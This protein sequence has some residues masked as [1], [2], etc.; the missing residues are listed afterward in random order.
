MYDAACLFE[1]DLQRA[2]GDLRV[3][4]HR[5]DDVSALHSLRQAGCLK[6]RFPHRGP[7]GWM[8][9][10]TVN[11]SGGIVGGD[12]LDSRFVLR[13]A[14][15][16]TIASQAAER[17][18]RALSG[19]PPACI[20]T[21]IYLGAAASA[22]WLPQETILFDRCALDRR[23]DVEMAADSWFLGLEMLVFGR[24]AMGEAVEHGSIRDLIR[25]RR[26]GRVILHDAVRLHGNVAALLQRPAIAAS[27]R[28]VATILHVAAQAEARLEAVRA[29]LA[30]IPLEA[31][32]S[33]WDGMLVIRLLSPDSAILRNAVIAVLRP[34]RGQRT[35][36]R[37]WGC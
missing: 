23:L 19:S 11:T 25:L 4:V 22:E 34:L 32:A 21:R 10:V 13:N 1:P 35:L 33:A 17:I 12:R 15:H 27:A 31:A 2:T 14:A 29:V 28:A 3:S 36:P 8:Q 9:L 24:A 18:Y 6:A 5:R 30:G 16:S 7:D 37:T 26:D 20:R